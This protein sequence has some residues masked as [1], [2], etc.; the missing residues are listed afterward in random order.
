MWSL[1]VCVCHCVSKTKCKLP[2]N[3]LE[4]NEREW[5]RMKKTTRKSFETSLIKTASITWHPLCSKFFHCLTHSVK[6]WCSNKAISNRWHGRQCRCRYTFEFMK[7]RQERRKK[8]EKEKNL[9]TGKLL[10]SS[11]STVRM[12]NSHSPDEMTRMTCCYV[13]RYYN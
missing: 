2:V 10:S 12:E 4:P 5:R 11:F 13:M 9:F 1:R 8:I 6:Q 7:K 3:S